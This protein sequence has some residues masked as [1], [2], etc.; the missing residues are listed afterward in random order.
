M[1]C[2]CIIKL[3]SGLPHT[4]GIQGN[5]GNSQVEENL[6]EYLEWDLINLVKYFVQEINFI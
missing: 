3:V 1:F 2:V 5:S 4:Q 6:R